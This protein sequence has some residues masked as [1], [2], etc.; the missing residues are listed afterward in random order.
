MAQQFLVHVKAVHT[1][2]SDSEDLNLIMIQTADSFE[3]ARDKAR[4]A[5]I[6]RLTEDWPEL[7]DRDKSYAQAGKGDCDDWYTLR[8]KSIDARSIDGIVIC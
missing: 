5:T 8:I 3:E 4:T 2:G 6:D 1:W 7:N